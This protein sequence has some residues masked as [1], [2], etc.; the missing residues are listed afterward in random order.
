MP[1]RSCVFTETASI[2]VEADE[3]TPWWLWPNLLS[4]DAPIVA[5]VWQAFFGR[6]LH[7]QYN[8]AVSAVLLLTVWLL[9]IADRCFDTLRFAAQPQH[10]ESPRHQFYRLH[11]RQVLPF[12]IAAVAAIICLCILAL[13]PAVLAWGA[14]IAAGVLIY[15]GLVHLTARQCCKELLVAVLFALGVCAPVAA[16][17]PAVTPA[18]ILTAVLFGILCWL[19]C[20]GIDRWEPYSRISHPSSNWIASHLS[21]TAAVIIGLAVLGCE[22]TSDPI[23]VAIAASAFSF[24]LL[25]SASP[26]LSPNA[27]RVLADVALLAP[28]PL[29]FLF[30]Q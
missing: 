22:L 16:A 24:I 7:V 11:R 26:R 20:A 5:V 9:Y 6:V 1:F 12:A 17:A 21:S 30:P 14:V 10:V 29:L 28:L 25:Q 23:F 15:F 2:S 3:K 13:P 8:A 27:L 19:N 18:A 4:L